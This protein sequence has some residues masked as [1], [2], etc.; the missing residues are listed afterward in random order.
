M[1]GCPDR[2]TGGETICLPVSGKLYVLYK[3]FTKFALTNAGHCAIINKS[4]DVN[5][6]VDRLLVCLAV[7]KTVVKG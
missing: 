7:F 3:K 6:E 1:T 2:E 4:C 5:L